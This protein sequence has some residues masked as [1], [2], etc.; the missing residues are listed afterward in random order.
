MKDFLKRLWSVIS[1]RILIQCVVLV[2]IFVT[3]WVC[4]Y[5]I[6]IL[7]GEEITK[8][9]LA[10]VVNDTFEERTTKGERGNIYDRSGRALTQNIQT[11]ALYYTPD[12][13]NPDLNASLNKLLDILQET[14][15]TIDL[16]T[17][18]P[19]VYDPDSG[20][21]YSSDYDVSANEIGFYNFLAEIY[22]TSRDKL[23]AQQKK[24]TATEAFTRICQETFEIPSDW[25]T[26]RQYDVVSIRY[27]IFTGRFYPSKPV[28]IMSDI[29]EDTQVKIFERSREFAGFSVEPTYTR[30]YPEGY[31]FAHIV[32]YMGQISEEEL[33]SQNEKGLSYEESD[34]IGKQGLEA[35]Y[36][37][38]LRGSD[39]LERVEYSGSTGERVASATLVQ[40]QQ[41][42]SLF[43]TIDRDVQKMAYDSLYSQ[44]KSLLLSKMT[45]VHDDE[46]GRTYSLR[47]VILALINN[48]YIPSQK[49]EAN[50]GPYSQTLTS[51]YTEQSAIET[52]GLK[53]LIFNQT[54]TPLSAYPDLQHDIYDLMITAMRDS[55]HLSYDYQEDEE[56]YPAYAN[57]QVSPL[58]FLRYCYEH[59]YLDVA[60]YGLEKASAESGQAGEDQIIS[61]IVSEEIEKLKNG[62]V[63]H[64][65]IYQ[66]MM[67]NGLF[68]EADFLELFYENGLISSD[69][70]SR[71]QLENGS[72]TPLNCLRQK[73]QNDEITPADINLDPCGGSVVISDPNSG[74]VLAMVSYPSYDPNR[75]MND[76]EYFSDLLTDNSGPLVFRAV[77][78]TRAIGS[79][80]KMCSSIAALDLGYITK[81]TIVHDNVTFPYANSVQKPRCWNGAGHGDVN[82][83]SAIDH[84]CNYFFYQTAYEM[85]DPNENHEF[86]DSVGLS[87]LAH[88]AQLLGL[89]EKTGIEVAEAEPHASDSDAVRSA[90][91]Q[92]T[93]A[94]SCA[95]L[96]RYT[97]TLANK[98]TVYDL[99]LVDEIHAP[100]GEVAY[101]S[102]PNGR[103][104]GLSDDLFSIVQEGM[105]AMILDEHKKEFAELEAVGLHTLGKTGTAEESEDHPEHSLFTGFDS[106]DDPKITVS[107]MI[108][109]GGGSSNAIP[110]FKDIVMKYYGLK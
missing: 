99:Y 36:E 73:I 108:P 45:G 105:R 40:S 33:N 61:Q 92:G 53:N 93:N 85:C 77:E 31:L 49:V 71:Q 1:S 46:Q 43:L 100:S 102:S 70:G 44:I 68:S 64:S 94:F 103:E 11:N 24:T 80:Y 47:D 15:E 19:I 107:V 37:D 82:V 76:A 104:T 17:D 74:E 42:S 16:E 60:S 9:E 95:N 22:N 18:F 8:E 110:V 23:T 38:F 55:E 83:V 88:Y 52:E 30:Q 41:G 90:I 63:L 75:I 21:Y 39:G 56:F 66:Y 58:T 28:R 59:D 20:F 10:A 98:G 27:A 26:K 14:G 3:I 4:L 79:T 32:G 69:D 91:G 54:G 106:A 51:L 84:S 97:D 109:F 29:S 67:E 12:T 81:D 86:D 48:N 13:D 78:E 34:S 62:R 2:G 7:R 89:A 87:K 35:V 65:R 96:N 25:D 50:P 57:G 72:L 101:K 5:R 6:Q